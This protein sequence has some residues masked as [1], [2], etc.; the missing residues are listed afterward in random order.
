M[1]R[2]AS[3]LVA[4]LSLL[5][6]CISSSSSSSPFTPSA[7]HLTPNGQWTTYH[8]DNAR[9]GHDPLAST[10]RSVHPTPSWH[11]V[12]L[13]GQVY[14]EPLI[15]QG[16]VY[17]ATLNNT[18]YALNQSDGSIVW[19][20][21]LGDPV[22]AGWACG[23]VAPQGILGTPVIDLSGHRIY[24]AALLDAD[25]AYSLFGLD[26]ATG[27]IQLQ[28]ALP[29]SALGGNFDWTIQQERGALSLANGYVY[30][31]FGGRDGDCGD[32]HGYIVGIPTTSAGG[33]HVY[34]TPGSG[35]GYWSP[36]GV[37]IDDSSGNLFAASGNA[38]VGNGC[39][40]NADGSPQF[41]NDAVIRLS[42][43]LTRAD[44][45]MPPDWQASW[46]RNDQDLG[47]S[48]P[49]LISPNLLFQSGKHGG[50]FLLSPSHLG[51]LGGQLFPDPL[52]TPYSQ[53]DTCLGSHSSATFGGIAYQSPFVYLECEGHGLVAL[54]TD[55]ATASFAVCNSSCADPDWHAGEGLT[56][57]PP[58]VA[59]GA[60][61]VASNGGG[62]YA[63]NSIT[64]DQ[65]YHSPGF[66]TN[67]F[68]TPSEAG[69]QVFVPTGALVKSFTF[70][71][72][73]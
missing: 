7:T 10:A 20:T 60:V 48:S 16:L 64:G 2:K 29:A 24:A 11:E 54:R 9:T 1:I 8:H 57:G 59:G 25:H 42:P 56:F 51:G 36:S 71:P 21:H 52:P 30:V 44:F 27:A 62:L 58:I 17:V 43:T 19:R 18:L 63:F 12:P 65:I 47:S 31:P 5:T 22:T 4:I 26:L 15:D 69:D 72:S 28:T 37:T 46:C 6:S 35:S 73:T 45:F 49:L 68:V 50:G 41:E 14:A 61:W 38:N 67:R 33:L 32:Y 70:A 66:A 39:N 23:N 40:A 55:S 53:A 3:L 34:R 13:D